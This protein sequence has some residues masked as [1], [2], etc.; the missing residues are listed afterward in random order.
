MRALAEAIRAAGNVFLTP[1]RLTEVPGAETWR[2]ALLVGSA[3]PAAIERAGAA[4]RKVT[5]DIAVEAPGGPNCPV[6]R[7]RPVRRRGYD[8][9]CLMLTGE[10][11]RG[12]KLVGLLSGARV[13][14]AYGRGGEWYQLRLPP[15]RPASLR[16]WARAV[17]AV[18]LCNASRKAGMLIAATDALRGLVPTCAGIRDPGPP[19]GRGV[20][21]I[22]PSYNQRQLMDFCLPPLLAEAGDRHRVLV[23]DDAS[24]DGTAEY[25]RKR[26][27]QV[28]VLRLRRNRGFA[29]A[30]RAG[31]AASGTPLFALINT[32]VQV[33]PGFLEAMLPHFDRAD[34]FAVCS[35]I[36]LPG[37]SQMET[38]NVAP[39]FSGVLEP[40]HVPPTEGGPIL[41]AGGASSVFHR[42]RYEALGGLE[43]IYRP[44]YWED[45]ELGYSAWRAGWRSLFEP[46]ASVFH[47]RRAWMG[48][49]FGDRYA[50]ETFL[51]NAL[52]FTWKNVRDRGLLAQHFAYV[53]ARLLREVLSGE[54][55]MFRALLRALPMLG[56]VLMKRWSAHRRG[57]LGDREILDMARPA[58]ARV[59]EAG[60]R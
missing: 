2:R 11:R 28:A 6:C 55:T 4:L 37:G 58:A 31:I 24:T 20:T 7:M 41:Y 29:G 59:G 34:T 9:A 26:Y 56:W 19:K 21:F 47:K 3:D 38:G 51:K 22:V 40:Y 36:D 50:N 25:V 48:K 12:E 8:V 14:L 1:V 16:W 18:M 45:I 52:V 44:L 57:D 15:F 23:V 43:T 17:L 13:A 49:R 39:A 5:P 46:G 42:A 10:G 33:R 35:R 27:P 32:D 54:G 60:V 53:W 30:V